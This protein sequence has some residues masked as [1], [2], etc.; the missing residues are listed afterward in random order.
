MWASTWVDEF[1]NAYGAVFDPQP[2]LFDVYTP[3]A[4]G[5]GGIAIIFGSLRAP[6]QRV[7]SGKWP[8]AVFLQPLDS[9][10][11]RNDER[12]W[13]I[14]ICA[15]RFL[16]RISGARRFLHAAQS[17]FGGTPC[18]PRNCAD[19][20]KK[21]LNFYNFPR[22]SAC[23]S[24]LSFHARCEGPGKFSWII[25]CKSRFAF[26]S[27]PAPPIAFP[28]WRQYSSGFAVPEP[29]CRCCTGIAERYARR[30]LSANCTCSAEPM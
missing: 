26:L 5:H 30:M 7:L 27:R 2:A 1:V 16:M 11:P 24:L 23:S 25:C 12:A 4:P 8:G 15:M 13:D 21:F 20:G 29:D 22:T 19:L 18:K 3:V 14:S 17:V 6:C 10:P 9:S 28:C